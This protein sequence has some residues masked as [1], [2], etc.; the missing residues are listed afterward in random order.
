[1][2][3]AYMLTITITT[4]VE[5]FEVMPRK[6]DRICKFFPKIHHHHHHHHHHLLLLLRYLCVSPLA[7]ELN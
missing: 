1:M 3:I 7:H 5:S 4:A 6:F 2:N